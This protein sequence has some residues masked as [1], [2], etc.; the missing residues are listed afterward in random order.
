MGTDEME[1][2]LKA[3][4]YTPVKYTTG[5]FISFLYKVPHGQFKGQEIEVALQAPQF[6]DIPPS[7]PYI[8]PLLLPFKGDGNQHPYD[9]VHDRKIPTPEFQY[10]SR[11]FPG[12]DET[13]KTMEV[14]LSFLRRLL[15]F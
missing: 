11:P 13:E 14:Y 3:M 7:G 5:D 2:Q 12:W 15:D 8:K 9:G 6:P 1:K 10:W 4:G